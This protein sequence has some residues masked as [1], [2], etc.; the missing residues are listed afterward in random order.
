MTGRTRR[1]WWLRTLVS[2]AIVWVTIVATMALFEGSLI[3]FPERYPAGAWDVEA[4]GRASGTRIRDRWL[5]AADGTRLHGW[6]CRPADPADPVGPGAGMVVLYF[7]GNAGNLSH[8]AEAVVELVR[9]PAEVFILDYRGYGRSEG[10]PG[11][12][13]LYLDARAAWRFLVESEGVDPDRI[14]LLGKSLGGAVA[15][16]LAAEVDPAGLILQSAFTSVPDMASRHYPFVPR[17]LIRTRMDS[18]ATIGRVSSPVLVIHS[19]DDE[20]VPYDMGRALYEAAGGEKRFHEV[21]GASH[22]EVALVGGG[23]YLEAIRE[24]LEHCRTRKGEGP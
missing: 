12:A 10:R 1:P 15:V 9:L 13:G 14:V 20:I 2:A 21:R 19:T 23:A 4:I 24:F 5:E 18:L 8:R 7:H 17:W 6:W 3:Y 22:N 11:E 16:D